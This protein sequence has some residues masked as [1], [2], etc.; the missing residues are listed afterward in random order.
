M[1]IDGSNLI[2]GRIG[3]VA[4]KK[5]LLGEKID[6]VNCEN[7]CITGSKAQILARYKQ[8]DAMG[9]PQTGPLLPKMAD[10]F[11]R[12][13][14]KRMLPF[15]KGRGKAA[16]KNIMCYIGVPDDMKDQKLETIPEANIS[17]VSSLKYVS[18]GDICKLLKGR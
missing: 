11:V 8:V 12:R 7:I 9:D 1:I 6:I 4:A 3:T 10:R 5:A 17:K 16:Y 13:A 2:L 18:V 14:I 15:K